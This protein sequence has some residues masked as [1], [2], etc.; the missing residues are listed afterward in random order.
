MLIRGTERVNSF[1]K[2]TGPR[3]GSQNPYVPI[4]YLCPRQSTLFF[5]LE[6]ERLTGTLCLVSSSTSLCQS[7]HQGTWS[8]LVGRNGDNVP[9]LGCA[10]KVC[11]RISVSCWQAVYNPRPSHPAI[12]LGAPG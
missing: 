9:R 3:G 12:L 10:E 4:H 5:Y 8:G 11:P 1:P 2:A 6:I 7:V